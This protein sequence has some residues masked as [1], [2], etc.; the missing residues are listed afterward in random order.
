MTK[1]IVVIALFLVVMMIP[2]SAFADMGIG[3]IAGYSQPTGVTF[4]MNNFPVVSLGWSLNGNWISGTVD[5]WFLNE[6]IDRNILWYLGAG[7]KA[8]I[9]D[10]IGLTFRV[11]VGIQ[12]YFMPA[13]ELFAELTPGLAILPASNFDFSGGIGLRYHFK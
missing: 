2:L 13:F 6:K 3:G 11:P 7:A 9:G 5:Y 10:T 12:W 8:S 1:K 4:K